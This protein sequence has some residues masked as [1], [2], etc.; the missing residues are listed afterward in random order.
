MHLAHK[1]S[2]TEI[3]LHF[4]DLAF[5]FLESS[6]RLCRDME[7]GA[8]AAD[9]HK[10][11]VTMLLAFHATELFLKGCISAGSPQQPKN[12]HSLGELLEEFSTLFPALNFEPPFGP[13]PVHADPESIAWALKTD[14][15]L[16][17]QL[18]YPTDTSGKP[19]QGER[20][21]SAE[22]FLLELEGLRSDFVRIAAVVF[23]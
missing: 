16:H 12:L 14:A 22:S 4:R 20:G 15:T 13:A 19:W 6:E 5:A 7:S 8:W 3:P 10:G 9:Y 2:S 1:Y 11:Q 18:R 21:F 17:Q 23:K